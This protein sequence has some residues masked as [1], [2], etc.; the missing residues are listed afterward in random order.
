MT[1]IISCFCHWFLCM[2]IYYL[3]KDSY[4]LQRAHWR[5][6]KNS[7]FAPN[8]CSWSYFTFYFQTEVL[9]SF[10]LLETEIMDHQDQTCT[11]M[12]HQKP[13]DQSS[14]SWAFFA[15]KKKSAEMQIA[16][17]SKDLSWCGSMELLV[18]LWQSWPCFKNKKLL[19]LLFNSELDSK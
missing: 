5:C 2:C 15:F 1:R 13:S 19:K 14:C 6:K 16:K 10:S 11:N 4:L 9:I 7:D 12:S 3:L 18:F 17:I 8:T